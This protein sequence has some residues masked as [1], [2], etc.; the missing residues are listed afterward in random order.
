MKWKTKSGELIDIRSMSDSHLQ[1]AIGMLERVIASYPGVQ[2]YVGDSEFAE[3]AVEQENRDN[4]LLL[5]QRTAAL[6]LMKKEL[7]S[8][9]T[10]YLP[11]WK[12]H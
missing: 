2:V 1:N 6:Q 9:N 12:T 4:R 8:R 11:L 10:H 7:A 3:S 5:T